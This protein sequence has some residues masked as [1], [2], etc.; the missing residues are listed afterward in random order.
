[1]VVTGQTG[2][3]PSVHVWNTETCEQVHSFQLPAGSRGVA[4]VSL[5]PCGRYVAAV[6]LH[7]DHRVT[8]FNIQREKQLLHIEGSK[9][10][11]FDIAWSKRADDFRFVTVSLK[12]IKFWHPAD[13]T[14]RLQQKGTFGKNATM[15]NLNCV[16]FDEEGWCYTGG[17]NGHI[18]VWSD[19]AQAV[20]SIKAHV[21]G[22]TGLIHTQGKLISAGN[23][24]DR[25]IAIISA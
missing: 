24:K 16:A 19:A 11:I 1:M 2:K 10:R 23:A 15:T 14:K 8:I 20:K 4:G 25:K 21:S 22:V 7:N 9:E 17:E 6:D 5:S 18:H 12:E 13:V 3:T